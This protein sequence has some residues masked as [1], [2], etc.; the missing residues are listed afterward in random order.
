MVRFFHSAEVPSEPP[1][2]QGCVAWRFFALAHLLLEAGY[3]PCP[4]ALPTTCPGSLDLQGYGA[5]CALVIRSCQDAHGVSFHTPGAVTAL[6]GGA[7]PFFEDI[8]M[9]A[10]TSSNVLYCIDE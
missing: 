2:K 9:P 3:S 8:T 6:A 7:A 1:G 4:S 5:Y 10:S